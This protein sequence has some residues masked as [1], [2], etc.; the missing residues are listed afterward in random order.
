M[1]KR[2]LIDGSEPEEIWIAISNDSD[3]LWV[4]YAIPN[5]VS[6]IGDIYS[7]RVE[8]IDNSMNAVFVDYGEKKNGFLQINLIHPQ[9]QHI[10]DRIAKPKISAANRVKK[11]QFITTQITREG[12]GN[13]CASMTTYICI[14]GRLC[15]LWP[16]SRNEKLSSSNKKPSNDTENLL[17]GIQIPDGME[18]TLRDHSDPPTK[19][20]LKREVTALLKIWENASN[21]ISEK[22]QIGLIHAGGD[23]IYRTLRDK[24]CNDIDEV[25]ASD[26]E[27]YQKIKSIMNEIL[28]S[29]KK[30]LKLFK[31]NGTLFDYY[32][33]Q[34]QWD[35]I[36]ENVV[37]LQSGGSIVINTTEAMVTIDVNSGK[38]KF[39][40]NSVNAALQT[41]L[42]ACKEIAKQ[43][44]LRDLSGIIAI[45]FIDMD[46]KS[47]NAT[48][49][50]ALYQEM[51]SDSARTRRSKINEL[52]V[53]LISRQCIDTKI[54]DKMTTPCT[55]CKGDGRVQPVS[56]L[57]IQV[58]RQVMREIAQNSTVVINV[59]DEV[60]MYILNHKRNQLCDLENT[61]DAKISVQFSNE[62]TPSVDV[63]IPEKKDV[64]VGNK[65]APSNPNDSVKKSPKK[66]EKDD[67]KKS[68]TSSVLSKWVSRWRD[69][70]TSK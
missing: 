1:I 37:H 21:K 4:D 13:K 14:A 11:G 70:L 5:K 34:K 62:I 41:N 49:E 46:A 20:E 19:R 53:L 27:T 18:I 2:L 66:K 40:K 69:A 50:Q 47:N 45:D 29:L 22:P 63:I 32:N 56:S 51:Q 33:L 35:Q 43:L 57:S 42:E 23:V 25:V 3:L 8:R 12:R 17:D 28:P 39:H 9:Y 44:S 65:E 30:K 26:K 68:D 67:H 10:S 60:G 48:V 54:S 24:C 61:Y 52:G 7:T 58:M 59:R 31:G 6:K 38:T 64:Q 55:H 36:S 15:K 16:Y